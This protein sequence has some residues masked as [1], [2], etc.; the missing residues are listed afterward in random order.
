MMK[1]AGGDKIIKNEKGEMFLSLVN[2]II[3][4]SKKAKDGKKPNPENLYQKKAV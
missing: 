2:L 1:I 4:S 3:N